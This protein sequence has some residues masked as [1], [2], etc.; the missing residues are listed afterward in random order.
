MKKRGYYEYDP[1][2]RPLFTEVSADDIFC[3][4]LTEKNDSE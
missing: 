2:R 1:V 4:Y 3:C